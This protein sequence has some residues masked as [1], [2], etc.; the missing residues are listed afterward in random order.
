VSTVVAEQGS[1]PA[2]PTVGSIP[3]RRGALA[4]IAV[5]GLAAAVGG[6]LLVAT[7]DHLVDPIAFGTQLFLMLVGTVAAA[8]YWL[9]RRPGNRLGSALLALAGATAVLTLQGASSPLLHSLGVAIEPVF[10]L[11]AYYV[12]FAFPDGRLV[13]RW[14]HALLAAMTLYFLTGFVP[15]LFF[16]PVVAGGAPLAGCD[17]CPENALMIADRPTIAASYGSDGSYAVIVIMS[18]TLACLIYRL[19]TATRPRRR[20]LVPVYVPA[21]GLTVPILVFHGVITELLSLSPD[22]I[23]KAGWFV[24]VSRIVLPYGFLLAI[25]LSAFFAATALKR[26]VGAHG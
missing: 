1:V 17:P 7:S 14:E 23:S 3:L 10:F 16:S 9:V 26:I 8:L 21:L 13:G 5:G 18:A 24:T 20:A 2:V 4:A 11:L 19:A 12:V 25:V 22:T 15:Y 6:G